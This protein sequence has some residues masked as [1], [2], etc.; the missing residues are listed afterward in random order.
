MRRSWPRPVIDANHT[1][2]FQ[3]APVYEETKK[4][5][6][7]GFFNSDRLHRDQCASAQTFFFVKYIRK[8]KMIRTTK[9][10]KPSFLR[11]SIFG[12]AAHIRKVVT[13]CAYCATVVGEP[14]SKVTW[15]SDSGF[16]ILMA[17]PGKYLL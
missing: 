1:S 6:S 3:D 4:P 10:W 9:T 17:W 14:S 13:S 11:A 15:P 7:G 12:S 16:G 5:P 8:A 2:S